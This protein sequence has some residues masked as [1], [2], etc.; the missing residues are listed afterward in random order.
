MADSLRTIDELDVEGRRVLL[1]AD[2]N[3]PL[4]RPSPAGRSRWPMT[5]ASARRCQTIA[6]LRGARRAARA[7]LASRTP[8]GHRPGAVDAPRGRPPGGPDRRTGDARAGGRRTRSDRAH[9][10]ACPGRHADAREHPLRA[11]RDPQRSRPGLGACRARR[12]VRERRLRHG[13]PGPREHGGHRP[14]AAERRRAADA[15]RGRRRSRRSSSDPA[16]AARRDPRRRQGQRQD[17]RR[18][19]VPRARR[20][21]AASAARCASR[22]SPPKV[23][24]W[25]RRSAPRTTSSRARRALTAAA[26]IL[27]PARAADRSGRSRATGRRNRRA[28]P[29]TA[30]TSP[31]AGAASTSDRE[32]A[33]ATPPR[34]RP[35]APCSGTGRW[36]RF[37]LEPFAAGTRAVAEAVASTP[38]TTVVGGGETVEAM[39]TFGL[40]DR[41]DPS[42]DRRRRDTRVTRGS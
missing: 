39:R 2:F 21:A 17:R 6:E 37:E 16:S 14:P 19:A 33:P 12:R 10:A 4:H 31:M 35:P 32:P 15:A 25:A 41:V 26:G 34:S 8:Q 36:A 40:A 27:V 11:G 42:L 20:C 38:A 28:G 29:S 24:A 23:I 7:R 30:S 13:A 5:P 3:V 18:R 1:R 9:R 22:S